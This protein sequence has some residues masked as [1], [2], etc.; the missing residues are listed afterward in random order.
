LYE[1]KSQFLILICFPMRASQALFAP[2]CGSSPFERDT[3][4]NNVSILNTRR[5]FLYRLC[6]GGFCPPQGQIFRLRLIPLFELSVSRPARGSGSRF[7]SAS[8]NA[9]N[10]FSH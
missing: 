6:A 1:F 10:S 5:A 2:I 7:I 4:I 9:R 8:L 3:F